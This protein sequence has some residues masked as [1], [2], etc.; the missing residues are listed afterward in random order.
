MNQKKICQNRICPTLTRKDK[1][2]RQFKREH[3]RG[4]K[5]EKAV[6]LGQL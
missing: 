1:K 5:E 3:C 2:N 6:L 4:R